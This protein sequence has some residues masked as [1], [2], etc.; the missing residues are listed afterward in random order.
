MTTLLTSGTFD[1][2]PEWP[3][4]AWAALL[5]A[6]VAAGVVAGLKGRWVWV[7]AGL[8]TAGLAWVP[9]A[10]LAPRP[11]SVLARRRDRRARPARLPAG[12]G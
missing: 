3:L 5:W 6:L 11:G 2:A 12:D 9:G 1:V 8:V 4:Y 7:V 10:L